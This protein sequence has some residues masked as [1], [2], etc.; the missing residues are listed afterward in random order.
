MAAKEKREITRE[1][2]EEAQRAEEEKWL[3]EIRNMEDVHLELPIKS[4][5]QY[6]LVKK[7]YTFVKATV[8]GKSRIA[9]EKLTSCHFA[10]HLTPMRL[11][12]LEK[13]HCQK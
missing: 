7:Y 5:E 11:K 9:F 10:D 2:F 12:F 13:C 6:E 3:Q 1:E 4:P 8:A